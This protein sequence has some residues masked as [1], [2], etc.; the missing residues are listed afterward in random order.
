MK[1]EFDKPILFLIFNRPDL[2]RRVFD[3]IRLIKPR[4][5]FIA[6]DGNRKDHLGEEAVCIEARKITETIDWDCKVYRLYRDENLGCRIAVSSAITWFFKNVECGIIL[7][8]DCLPNRSFFYF[9]AELLERYKD[10]NEI[11]VISGSNHLPSNNNNSTSYYFS[12]YPHI[13][14]WASWRRFWEQYDPDIELWSGTA[15]DLTQHLP[16]RFAVNYWAKAFNDVKFNHMDTWDIQLV[17]LC[18]TESMCCVV[19]TVNLITNIG[20]DERATHTAKI[21]HWNAPPTG[22]EI[23]FP[24]C[25]PETIEVSRPFDRLDEKKSWGIPS[26]SI[27]LVYDKVYLAIRIIG[28]KFLRGLKLR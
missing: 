24:L 15:K 16:N 21:N 13:W 14:G 1:P 4:Q 7:E 9:C 2:T 11:G 10:S 25:H 19:P 3:E 18:V 17:H 26:S 23:N 12:I 8:D 27:E 6:A 22:E 5:L 20:F 28:G